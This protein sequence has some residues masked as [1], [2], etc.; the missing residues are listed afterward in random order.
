MVKLHHCCAN[1]CSSD[2]N[3][4]GTKMIILTNFERSEEMGGCELG[5][6]TREESATLLVLVVG[7]RGV[8]PRLKTSVQF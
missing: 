8:G 3:V 6:C 2:K 5:E 4:S 7:I 1:M